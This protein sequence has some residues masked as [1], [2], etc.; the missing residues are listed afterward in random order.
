MIR[1]IKECIL[2][3]PLKPSIKFDPLIINKKQRQ[4]KNKANMSIFI[5]WSKYSKEILS[6]LNSWKIIRNNK[7]VIIIRSLS[8]GLISILRSSK[9][10]KKKNNIENEI[11][12][13][14]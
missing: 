8:F 12:S 10:P 9:N 2:N 11:Y 7:N 5:R 6:I 13:G 14:K 3:K 1:I 4:T